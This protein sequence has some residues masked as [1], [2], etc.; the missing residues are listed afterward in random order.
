[1]EKVN[2][3]TPTCL[4]IAVGNTTCSVNVHSLLSYGSIE[5]ATEKLTRKFELVKRRVL[6][7]T[8]KASLEEMVQNIFATYVIEDETETV[9]TIIQE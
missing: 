4:K 1:M 8:E 9:T 6:K 7:D 5:G 2:S 3:K